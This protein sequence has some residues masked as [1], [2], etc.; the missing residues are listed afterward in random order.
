MIEARSF[1]EAAHAQGY[2]VYAGVPCSLLGPL[3]DHIRGRS[4]LDYLVAANE[5][6]A[7]AVA[8]GSVLGGRPAVAMMQNSGLGNAVNPLTSLTWPFRIPILLIVTWRGAPGQTDEAQHRLMGRITPTLLERMEIP[9]EPFPDTQAG[10]GPALS[11][12]SAHMRRRRR[13]YALIA[14]RGA[15]APGAA[16]SG[17]QIAARGTP[18]AF[19]PAGGERD[20]AGRVTRRQALERVVALTDPAATVVIATTGFTG[21]ELYAIADRANHLY[22]VGSMGCAPALGLGLALARPDLRVVVIDGDGAALMRLGNLATVGAYAQGNLIHILLDNGVHDSTGGQATVSATMS[23]AG[24]AAACGYAQ[25][26][27]G[28]GLGLLER[29]LGGK[30]LQGPR[31]LQLQTRPGA[32]PRLPRPAL[33]PEQVTAR[34]M[35]H[36]ERR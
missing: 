25:V 2:R 3:I 7:V 18:A 19:A 17:A 31:F 20:H 33:S 29:C 22:M 30:D 24:V 13:P 1:A 28:E 14:R 34:L 9:W 16:P 23:F 6:D 35:A 27:Q 12:A 26:A 4:D 8:A 15:L 10:I 32:G 5:G 11:R 36:I 21:R